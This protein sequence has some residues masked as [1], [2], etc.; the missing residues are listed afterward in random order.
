MRRRFIGGAAIL[1]AALLTTTVAG[2]FTPLNVVAWAV[3]FT[4]LFW[5]YA[6]GRSGLEDC[7][8]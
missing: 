7:R 8:R 4:A 2:Q 3:F 5:R 1:G 6:F